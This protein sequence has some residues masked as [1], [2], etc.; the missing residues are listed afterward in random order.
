MY[1][2]RMLLK[3]V[4]CSQVGSS[5]ASG[6]LLSLYF[7]PVITWSRLWLLLSLK[8]KLCVSSW[9]AN[10]CCTLA[11]AQACPAQP[12]QTAHAAVQCQKPKIWGISDHELPL[13]GNLAPGERR[14]LLAKAVLVGVEGF[15]AW[16]QYF[17]SGDKGSS[18]A[19]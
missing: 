1:N 9:R 18:A 8:V 3:D 2:S 15:C 4:L 14:H 5:W 10:T 17:I 7:F 12:W 11:G 16:E 19:A 13:C 6:P